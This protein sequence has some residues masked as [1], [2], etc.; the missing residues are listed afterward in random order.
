[1]SHCQWFFF[2]S[3]FLALN[4]VWILIFICIFLDYK[5]IPK[6]TLLFFFFRNI[7]IYIKKNTELFLWPTNWTKK[8]HHSTTNKNNLKIKHTYQ[9]QINRYKK[10]VVFDPSK[11]ETYRAIQDEQGFGAPRVHEIPITV[12]HQTYQPAPGRVSTTTIARFWI[13]RSEIRVAITS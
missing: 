6:I 1:M 5:I 11:S 8:K 13:V 9:Q 2:R 10:T 7:Y 12:Q 3:F 4:F